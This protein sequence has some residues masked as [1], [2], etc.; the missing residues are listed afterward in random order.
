MEDIHRLAATEK[1][2]QSPI[3]RTADVMPTTSQPK[4]KA[5]T[6]QKDSDSD[7]PNSDMMLPTKNSFG[8]MQKYKNW[9]C[10]H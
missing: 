1:H 10:I 9:G 4:K 6:P 2:L 8:K 7:S 5:S 3:S